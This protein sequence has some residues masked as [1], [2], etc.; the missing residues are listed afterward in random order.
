MLWEVIKGQIMMEALKVICVWS[1]HNYLPA[2][3]GSEKL[4]SHQNKKEFYSLVC[5][6]LNVDTVR[7]K[8]GRQMSSG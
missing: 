1:A 3:S 8:R 5:Y 7:R 4:L 2:T 6:S